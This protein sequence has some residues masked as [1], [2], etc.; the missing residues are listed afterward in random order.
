MRERLLMIAALV[1]CAALWF[2]DHRAGEAHRELL[3][4]QLDQASRSAD[5][6]AETI[7]AQRGQLEQLAMVGAELVRFRQALDKQ[8]AAQAQQ[9]KELKENDQAAALWL[10]G[11]VPGSVG[12]LFVYPETTDPDA[13][14][15]LPAD[16]VSS[17]G[18]AGAGRQ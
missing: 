2:F 7:K 16:A 18:T 17:T 1:V 8:G 13:Y 14:T 4:V 6:R 11:L 10:A 9:L 15:P 5:E 12:R 3:A